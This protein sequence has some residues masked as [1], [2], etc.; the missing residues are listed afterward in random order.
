MLRARLYDLEARSLL[1]FAG[2]GLRLLIWR[3]ELLGGRRKR[4]RVLRQL[5]GFDPGMARMLIRKGAALA[6]EEAGHIVVFLLFQYRLV[7]GDERGSN[8]HV[9]YMLSCGVHTYIGRTALQRAGRT[10]PGPTWR[11]YEHQR[12]L[13]N[14]S[15]GKL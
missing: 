12:Q 11:L 1:Q 8:Q 2:M 13:W 14:Q 3:S 15:R 4:R 7:F 6:A 9:V 10:G 5:R